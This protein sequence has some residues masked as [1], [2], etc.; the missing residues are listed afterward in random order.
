MFTTIPEEDKESN[1]GDYGEES[2]DDDGED[3]DD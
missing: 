1:F 3:D 2:D